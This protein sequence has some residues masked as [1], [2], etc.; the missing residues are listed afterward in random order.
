MSGWSRGTMFVP[1]EIRLVSRGR[2]GARVVL[3]SESVSSVSEE[4]REEMG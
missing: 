2:R 1:L 3:R 4:V